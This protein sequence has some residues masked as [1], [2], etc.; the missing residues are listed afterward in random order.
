MDSLIHPKERL[1]F[2]ICAI[3]TVL[4]YGLILLWAIRSFRTFAPL[5]FYILLFCFVAF[6][7]K[8]LFIGHLRGN[9]VRVTDKQFPEVYR[10]AEMLAQRLELAG[11][12]GIYVL[13]SGGLLNAFAA[14]FL[15]RNFVIIYS[16]ILSL[17][18]EQGASALDFV[19]CHELAHVKR[20]H[21]LWRM[22]LLPSYIIPFLTMA[23]S[24]ACE[25]TCDRFG[26]HYVPEGAVNGIL[27]LAAGK[28]LS[29]RVNVGEYT[30]QIQAERGF[31]VWFAE[32]LAS[33]PNLPKRVRGV[34]QHV[35][36]APA[37]AF[38]EVVG[39]PSNL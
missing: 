22:A 7:S 10:S 39:S 29:G 18:Y 20:R 36:L 9:G 16:E 30:N 11:M 34:Q 31:F 19:A 12:P 8:G 14:K 23:Y 5:L 35:S 17:A 27:V 32:L 3:V 13:Q 24:R 26:A 2:G 6:I 33:H 1:Y 28:K 15:G 21:M 4:V 37:R 38:S 25:Y